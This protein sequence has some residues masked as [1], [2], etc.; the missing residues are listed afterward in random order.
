[1]SLVDRYCRRM[2]PQF[3]LPLMET[4]KRWEPV[5]Q[6]LVLAWL[7]RRESDVPACPGVLLN[8]DAVLIKAPGDLLARSSA[9][10]EV[11]VEAADGLGSPLPVAEIKQIRTESRVGDGTVIAMLR[12]AVPSDVEVPSTLDRAYWAELRESEDFWQAAARIGLV[13]GDLDTLTPPVGLQRV[14][15][16][17]PVLPLITEAR[18]SWCDIFWW[19][20]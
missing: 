1:V 2:S 7:R 12:L 4:V 17:A 6:R 9:G 3:A 18:M 10:P 13:P 14:P 11:V 5:Q 20:C 15:H 19:L 8:S 16:A